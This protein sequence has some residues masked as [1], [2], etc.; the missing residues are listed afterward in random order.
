MSEE[1]GEGRSSNPTA[2]ISIPAKAASSDE[3]EDQ[4]GEGTTP[5]AREFSKVPIFVVED[6]HDVLTFL[7]RCLGSRHLPLLGN[8]IIHFDSH[9]DMCIP[10]HMPAGYVFNKEDLLDSISIENWL[11]PTVFAGHVK[12]IVWIKPDWSN[13]IPKGKFRFNVGEYEGSIRTDSTLEYFVSEGCYQPE[14]N[15]EN[16]KSLDLEV[17]S[18]GEYRAADDE[19]LKD[20]YIL[21]IDLDYF[22][23]HNPFLKIYEKVGLYDKLKEIFISPELADS[24]ENDLEKLQQLAKNRE[25]KLEFLE[26]MFLYLEEVGNLKHFLI[27]YQQEIS[28]EYTQLLQKVSALVTILKKEYSEDEIDWSMI[29]DA[30]C[31]CDAT[32]LPH[33]ESTME[34]IQSMVTHLEA[35]LSCLPGPPTVITVSRS[36]EDDYTPSEQVEMIQELVLASLKKCLR[37]ELDEP[38]LYYKDQ[39]L[40]L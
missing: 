36:S 11:M 21:D 8:T 26:S 7:Y 19:D 37:T 34:E 10:K 20:G 6:H 40:K 27:D 13:Q 12:R 33:H 16:K 23:T 14:E 2:S 17:C 15:L 39:E 4:M 9:P 22:S 32:D 25:E 24:A 38:T 1:D 3:H 31:T 18:I 28:E 29:Y 30:G 5:G 35:F